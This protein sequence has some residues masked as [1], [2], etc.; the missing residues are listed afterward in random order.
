M[1]TRIVNFFGHAAVA[2][3]LA[4]APPSVL[5]SMLP[6]FATMCRGRL[7]EPADAGIARGVALHH[8]TDAAFHQ[9]PAVLALMREADE[10]L[11][12]AGCGRGPR[13]A[14]SHIGVELLLD[15][16]LVAERA[17]RDGY[18]AGL[19][20]DAS[21]VRWREEDHAER[22]ALLLA[23]LRA[24]GVPDDLR[25]PEAIVQRLHRVLAH[26]PLLAPNADD[27]RAIRRELAELKPRVEVAA[28]AIMRPLLAMP[29]AGDGESP[30]ASSSASRP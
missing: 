17:Y 10:R 6:D 26:R 24:H 21:G 20:H 30:A 4:P 12:R 15:G 1:L 22:F 11:E 9:M 14:A 25:H 28:D 16:V 2:S 18:T 27:L 3:A 5:G 19:A 7:A 8:A 13:M 29:G 23:R